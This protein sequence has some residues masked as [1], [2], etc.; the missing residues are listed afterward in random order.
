MS[1]QPAQSRPPY[2]RPVISLR[3][4]LFIPHRGFIRVPG[5]FEAF[6]NLDY[7]WGF[8]DQ[9]YR[10][11]RYRYWT[12]WKCTTPSWYQGYVTWSLCSAPPQYCITLLMNEI[13]DLPGDGYAIPVL[14]EGE[15]LRCLTL[16]I[17]DRQAL[18]EFFAAFP[19]PL[20]AESPTTETEFD[21]VENL[22]ELC[23][24]YAHQPSPLDY[25]YRFW[26]DLSREDQQQ[27]LRKMFTIESLAT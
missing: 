16:W 9:G 10:A 15:P 3:E 13:N 21:I 6:P 4:F 11:H 18:R 8:L 23:D 25:L 7:F 17:A 12:F 1:A 27:F 20:F 22:L 14:A 2:T 5:D 24:V 19:F 26:P